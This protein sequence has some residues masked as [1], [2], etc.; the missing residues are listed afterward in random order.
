MDYSRVV[1]EVK[2]FLTKKLE[3]TG[4]DGY[5]IG[6]SGGIDSAV[7]A[8]LAVEAVGHDNVNGWGDARGSK[9][10]RKYGRRTKFM[11]KFRDKLP[12]NKYR[13]YSKRV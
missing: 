1:D 5:V 2:H 9:Q 11:P 4:A 7:T 13:I 8:K 12:G 3:E 10:S 6:L